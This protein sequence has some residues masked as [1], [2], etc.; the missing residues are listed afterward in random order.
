MSHLPGICEAPTATIEFVAGIGSDCDFRPTSQFS[1]SSSVCIVLFVK[2]KAFCL[3]EINVN[4]RVNQ[5]E[6]AAIERHEK[7]NR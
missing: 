1:P 2:S 3:L 5:V 7:G 6:E 4:R